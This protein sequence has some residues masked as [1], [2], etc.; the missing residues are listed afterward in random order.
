MSPTYLNPKWRGQ[1]A[2]R[3]CDREINDLEHP[4]DRDAEDTERQLQEPDE[5]IGDERQKGQGPAEYEENAPQKECEHE[6]TFLVFLFILRRRLEESS[7]RRVLEF[8]RTWGAVGIRRQEC[9]RH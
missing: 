2:E 6:A 4:V 1:Q 7:I 5:R 9:P 3:K 8:S